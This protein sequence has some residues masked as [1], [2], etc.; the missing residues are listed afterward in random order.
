M[1]TLFEKHFTA[2]EHEITFNAFDLPTGVYFYKLSSGHFEQVKK[3]I[4]IK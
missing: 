1:F 3:M 4:V 2:G